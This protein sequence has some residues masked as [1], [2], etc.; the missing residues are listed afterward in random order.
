MK[1]L[2]LFLAC[3]F[4]NSLL[5]FSQHLEINENVELKDNN[6]KGDVKLIVN[7]IYETNYESGGYRRGNIISYKYERYNENGKL[8]KI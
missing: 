1:S 4:A 3:Y 7:K 2:F 5:L 8:L 6:L